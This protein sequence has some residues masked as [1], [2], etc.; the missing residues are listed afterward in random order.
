MEATTHTAS[1]IAD[2]DVARCT[3]PPPGMERENQ[4]LLVI[5]ASAEQ[6]SLGPSSDNPERSTTD[7]HGGNT[8][9]NPWMAAIFSGLTWAISYGGSTMKELEEWDR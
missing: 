1:P 3:T 4:Y 8:F 2:E 7:S 9:Q 5:T 6:L